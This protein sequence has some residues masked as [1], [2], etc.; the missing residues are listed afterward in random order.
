MSHKSILKYLTVAAVCATSIATAQTVYSTNSGQFVPSNPLADLSQPQSSQSN[1][2]YLGVN[3]VVMPGK[4]VGNFHA[5]Q[6][7][8]NVPA[9]QY[10]QN[11]LARTPAEQLFPQ[12]Q[13]T[14]IA[15]IMPQKVSVNAAT[16]AAFNANKIN[17]DSA[18]SNATKGFKFGNENADVAVKPAPNAS[19]KVDTSALRFYASQR[20]LQRVGIEMRRLQAAHP[21]WTPP[22]DLF[23]PQQRIDEQPLWDLFAVGSYDRIRAEITEIKSLHPEWQ[24][25]EDLM[26]KLKVAEARVS[27]E[28][29][30]GYGDW[31]TVV[32]I[33]AREPNL[34]V[35]EEVQSLWHLGETLARMQ[36]YQRSF[37]LY[38]YVLTECDNPNERFATVQKASLLLPPNG[39]QA[40]VQFGKTLPNGLSEFEEIS[41]DLLRRQIGEI[42]QNGRDLFTQIDQSQLQ[43]YA[44]YAIKSGNIDDL[45]LIGWYYYSQEQYAA[46]KEWFLT[47]ARVNRDPKL[48]EGL[49]LSLRG[50][51]DY[52]SAFDLAKTQRKSSDEINDQYIQIVSSALTD[53]DIE[54]K[55][56]DKMIDQ[57]EDI[58]IDAESALGAQSIGWHMLEEGDLTDA[59]DW[60]TQSIEWDVNE[61]AVIGL[62]VRA[63]RAK[64]HRTLR[65]IIRKYGD[66]Y[67]ALRKFK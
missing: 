16:S 26:E 1:S 60:F 40:L 24:P 34:L 59:R 21:G 46:S 43:K 52:K 4:P 67:A 58:V 36:D 18:V 63:A 11:L 47:G 53:E 65:S 54:L 33:A 44:N 15:P 20:D 35:C 61:E 17:P 66:E 13:P 38:K 28:R 56:T 7:I 2:N 31:A 57:F 49:I 10:A 29:A 62:A 39:I 8:S 41:Y 19:K 9:N 27:L 30:F 45:G 5:Q 12:Q 64:H 22:A 48:I 50:M 37:D 6:P 23:S 55:L 32:S 25:S 3:Q 51:G 42:T 14:N